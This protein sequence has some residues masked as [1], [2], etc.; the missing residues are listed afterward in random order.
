MK[1]VHRCVHA[2]PAH[3]MDGWLHVCSRANELTTSRHFMFSAIARPISTL[4]RRQSAASPTLL[5][6]HYW[7]HRQESLNFFA[8]ASSNDHCTKSEACSALL[9]CSQ[10]AESQASAE[11]IKAGLEALNR[12]LWG[13]QLDGAESIGGEATGVEEVQ[14]GSRMSTDWVMQ[15]IWCNAR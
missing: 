2:P 11:N 9:A 7:T 14:R 4:W 13:P 15:P 10:N 3:G 1:E 6:A 12:S 8:L 5:S